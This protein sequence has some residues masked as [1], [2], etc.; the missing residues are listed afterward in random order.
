MY[1]AADT[2][3]EIMVCFCITSYYPIT[4]WATSLSPRIVSA[5][6]H[7]LFCAQVESN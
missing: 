6:K 3:N 7:G 2:V 4:L 1:F 5:T